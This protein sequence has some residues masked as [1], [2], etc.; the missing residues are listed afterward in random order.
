MHYY[1]LHL[2]FKVVEGAVRKNLQKWNQTRGPKHALLD[3][4]GFIRVEAQQ[5]ARGSFRQT[6]RL[7]Q[8]QLCLEV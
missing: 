7:I 5:L 6:E 4:I 1:L 3:L 8:A 2:F